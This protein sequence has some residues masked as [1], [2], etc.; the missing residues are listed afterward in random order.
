[1][2]MSYCRFEGT[3]AELRACLDIVDEHVNEE[4][5]YPVSEDEI[6]HFR[7]MVLEFA[8]WLQDHSLIDE[9]GYVDD[10]ALDEVCVAMGVA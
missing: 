3:H 1:M 8:S 6:R 2:Y 9:D 5:E 7:S 10:A 4:A